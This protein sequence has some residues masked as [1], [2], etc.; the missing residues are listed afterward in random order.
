[1][2]R[3]LAFAGQL[4]SAG[5][6][7]PPAYIPVSKRT[8]TKVNFVILIVAHFILNKCNARGVVWV[9][10]RCSRY[11]AKIPKLSPNGEQK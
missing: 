3:K 1:M 7:L 11:G 9:D 4:W 6:M 5:R 2:L 8:A 10:K